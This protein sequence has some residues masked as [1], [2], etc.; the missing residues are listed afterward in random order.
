MTENTTL[1]PNAS[2][3]NYLDIVVATTLR[4][5][6]LYK[7]EEFG[8]KF[9]YLYKIHYDY[10]GPTVKL[11]RDGNAI[12]NTLA[13]DLADYPTLGHFQKINSSDLQ[14]I[15]KSISSEK[16]NIIQELILCMGG[17]FADQDW[18][19]VLEAQSQRRQRI[20]Q[21]CPSEFFLKP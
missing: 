20:F 19:A 3:G 16:S 17:N 9:S 7:Q 5:G 14:H 1:Q 12:Y 21:N 15:H 11:T 2:A 4:Y 6:F 13:L 8:R 18:P 10:D